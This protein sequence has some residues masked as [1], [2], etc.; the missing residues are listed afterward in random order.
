[1]IY[2]NNKMSSY[3]GKDNPIDLTSPTPKK[4]AK[5]KPNNPP[6]KGEKPVKKKKA[7]KGQHFMPDGSLMKDSDMPKKKKA[8]AKA[9]AKK[10]SPPKVSKKVLQEGLGIISNVAKEKMDTPDRIMNDELTKSKGKVS[11]KYFMD[12]LGELDGD[13][14]GELENNINESLN[15]E[16]F[17]HNKLNLPNKDSYDELTDKQQERLSKIVDKEIRKE[18]KAYNR[19]FFDEKIKGK[20]FNLAQLKKTIRDSYA[21]D[22]F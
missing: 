1:M 14:I 19:K 3:G 5:K 16:F 21:I 6:K 18:M 12:N 13:G 9:P 8:P 22:D 4:V 11:F 20:T 10:K 17:I 2:Y 7:P 15:I